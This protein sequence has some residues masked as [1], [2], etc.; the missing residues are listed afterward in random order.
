MGFLPKICLRNT[1]DTVL[2]RP[3]F[4]RRISEAINSRGEVQM[5]NFPTLNKKA[6][7]IVINFVIE[8]TGSS[9]CQL[10]PILTDLR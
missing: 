9:R 4:A 3:Y 5:R 1:Y 8:Y 10:L 6:Q 7:K 2:I